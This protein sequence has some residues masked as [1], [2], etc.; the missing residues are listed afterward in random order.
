LWRAARELTGKGENRL[1]NDALVACCRSVPQRLVGWL[2]DPTASVRLAAAIALAEIGSAEVA[3]S[4]VPFTRDPDPEVRARLVDSLGARA[5]LQDMSP[6]DAKRLVDCIVE[7]TR[8]PVWFVRVRALDA[9]ARVAGPQHIPRILE[10][11]RDS[12][13][14]VRQKAAYA[15]RSARGGTGSLKQL[16]KYLT[17]LTD[18][19]GRAALVTD[20]EYCGITWDAINRLQENPGPRV[21]EAVEFLQ[22]LARLGFERAAR[23]ALEYH[24]VELVRSRLQRLLEPQLQ[25]V[26]KSP[27]P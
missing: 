15:L 21:N 18:N 26:E 5:N 27:A 9:L 22:T 25:T 16:A 3:P 2:V 10:R 20:L 17:L 19:Y 13:W 4:L 12:Q 8:D 7:Q 6:D 14:Q 11:L 23:Y 1:L 24:P